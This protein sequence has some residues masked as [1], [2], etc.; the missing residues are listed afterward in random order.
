MPVRLGRLDAA[1]PP[2]V[3]DVAAAAAE[4]QRLVPELSASGHVT[5]AD[6]ALLIGYCLKYAQWLAVEQLAARESPTITT[7]TGTVKVHPLHVQSRAA[8][9]VLLKVAGELGITPI[10]RTRVAPGPPQAPV[11]KWDGALR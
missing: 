9:V 2:E 3:A 7:R 4:W 6:R 10:T 1:V 8:F 11:S 5:T